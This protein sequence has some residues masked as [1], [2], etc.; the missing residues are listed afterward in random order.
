MEKRD[1]P[2]DIVVTPAMIEAGVY[3]VQ[4]HVL[5]EGFE[6]LVRKVYIAMFTEAHTNVSA[7]ATNDLK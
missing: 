5:G 7:S 6:E 1:R 3:E 4:E 2:G